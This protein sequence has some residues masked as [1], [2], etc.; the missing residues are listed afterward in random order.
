MVELNFDFTR[1]AALKPSGILEIALPDGGCQRG[2]G[3]ARRIRRHENVGPHPSGDRGL[4]S[5]TDHRGP[6]Y[7]ARLLCAERKAFIRRPTNVGSCRGRP[8]R[9]T[10]LVGL[11]RRVGGGYEDCKRA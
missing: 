1:S 4:T 3:E 2:V 7:L 5:T 11:N 8:W 6:H 10:N 9:R